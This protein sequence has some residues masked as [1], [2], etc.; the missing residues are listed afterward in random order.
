MDIDKFKAAMQAGLQQKMP[1]VNF[2]HTLPITIEEDCD[3][4][5]KISSVLDEYLRCIQG[6][7]SSEVYNKVSQNINSIKTAIE[8]YYE[9]NISEAKKAIANVLKPYIDDK[10]IV[11][12][13]DDSPALR[14]TTRISSNS[15][16][17]QYS[18]AAL[19][20]FKARPS[21]ENYSRE[22]FLHIPFNKRGKVTTQRF[23][24][25][26]VPCMYFGASSYVCWLE[27][28][29]PISEKFTI[30]SY[31]VPKEI[32]ILNL[33]I[34]KDLVHGFSKQNIDS[35]VEFFPVVIATSFT[36]SDNKRQFKSEYIISQLIMQSLADFGIDGVA[37]ISKRIEHDT[38]GASTGN[39]NFP[40]CVNLAIP[41][42]K[43]NPGIY[44]KFAKNLRLTEP[45]NYND[46]L[47]LKPQSKGNKISYANLFEQ[48]QVTEKGQKINYNE[49]AYSKFDDYLVNMEHLNYEDK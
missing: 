30:S 43:D 31:E 9:A 13:L 39:E 23:S 16:G 34:T 26:G 19:T 6:T 32:K 4:E 21:N 41:M 25:A 42:K 20:F 3:Y 17:K 35:L 5:K 22:K 24:I 28:G 1:L 15:I 7:I 11:S 47:I 18:Q 36:V 14:G 29:K 45:S 37:Y 12:S 2:P 33:A 38:S 49:L 10:Y 40:L 46:Y 44:S 48:A 8:Y 27:L